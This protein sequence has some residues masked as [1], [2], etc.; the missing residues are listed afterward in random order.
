MS[1]HLCTSCLIN[2]KRSESDKYGV[3]AIK[4]SRSGRKPECIIG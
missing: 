1:E 4:Q 3:R 2:G